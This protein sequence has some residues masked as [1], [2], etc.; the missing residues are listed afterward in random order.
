[1]N[2]TALVLVGIASSTSAASAAPRFA[3]TARVES[4]PLATPTTDF[5]DWLDTTYRP[6]V[7]TKA[8]QL[9][10]SAADALAG[11]RRLTQLLVAPSVAKKQPVEVTYP[12]IDE[13]GDYVCA[14]VATK[15]GRTRKCRDRSGVSVSMQA[16]LE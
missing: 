12:R 4:T 8:A 13:S 7:H 14:N 16:W 10:D 11:A 3:D 9:L 5:D 6:G 15:G 2:K 1:M